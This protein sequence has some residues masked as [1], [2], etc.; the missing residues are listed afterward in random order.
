MGKAY[1]KCDLD[2]VARLIRLPLQ[3]HVEVDR[4]HGAVAEL[5]ADRVFAGGAVNAN[6]LTERQ[7]SGSVGPW[8]VMIPKVVAISAAIN[9]WPRQATQLHTSMWAMCEPAPIHLSP[10]V[11]FKAGS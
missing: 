4:P 11:A 10:S 3:R 7:A 8:S 5:F 9:I 2:P 6:Q 1:R